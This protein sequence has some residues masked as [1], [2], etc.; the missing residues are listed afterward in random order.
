[1]PTAAAP[2]QVE[3][4]S[5]GDSI[6]EL[7][8]L[9]G[10]MVEVLKPG[11]DDTAEELSIS[12]AGHSSIRGGYARHLLDTLLQQRQWSR[13]SCLTG[14]HERGQAPSAY[15]SP[16]WAMQFNHCAMQCLKGVGWPCRS[17]LGGGDALGEVA[18]F[19]EIA[20][21][22]TVR[23]VSVCRILVVPRIAYNS[24]AAAFP[25]G[26]RAILT[27][28]LSRAQEVRFWPCWPS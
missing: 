28:L 24:I 7:M 8:L 20:Q 5:E 16:F 23:T 14:R 3:I 18:F 1:M 9:V 12:M 4:L 17:I 11:M 13:L 19:T 26:A 27:N 21:L 15:L 2:A 22:E 25:I 6:N 10:G